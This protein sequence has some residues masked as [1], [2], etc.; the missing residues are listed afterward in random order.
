MLNRDEYRK[1]KSFSKDEMDRWLTY[2]RNMVYNQLR[3]KFENEYQKELQ[4]SIDNFITAIAYTLHF[5]ESCKFGQQ[6]LTDFM[7]DML[8]TVDMFRTGEYKPQDYQ[9][10]LQ[11]AGIKINAYDYAK[12]YKDHDA[13]VRKEY[14]DKISNLEERNEKALKWLEEFSASGGTSC[15]LGD[16]QTLENILR[17]DL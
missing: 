4:C 8:V 10:E 12:L 13:M 17:G 1:I 9:E 14:D 7:E 2:D 15:N 5:N 11:K 16:L 3:K 6:R